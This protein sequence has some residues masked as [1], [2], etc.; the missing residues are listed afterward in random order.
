M[1][2]G[3][4]R[5]QL[6]KVTITN[7]SPALLSLFTN[8]VWLHLV[9]STEGER[10]VKGLH[11]KWSVSVCPDMVALWKKKGGGHS[12]SL[13]NRYWKGG[14]E[15]GS[16]GHRADPVSQETETSQLW[17]ALAQA[18]SPLVVPAHFLSQQEYWHTVDSGAWSPTQ[19]CNM[20]ACT[21]TPLI[22]NHS[23]WNQTT[24]VL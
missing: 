8:W 21:E 14:G 3:H 13:L 20:W 6:N 23:H 7:A 16:V 12:L 4:S 9:N 22:C 10:R 17:S 18:Q 24:V 1:R 5:N 19:T 15:W 2:A 11:W